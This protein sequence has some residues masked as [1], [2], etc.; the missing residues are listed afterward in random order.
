MVE[1]NEQHRFL[2]RTIIK[3]SFKDVNLFEAKNLK[4]A[5]GIFKENKEILNVVL[6]DGML[7]DG[8]GIDFIRE[9]RGFPGKIVAMPTDEGEEGA[10][11]KAKNLYESVG[12]VY[13]PKSRLTKG[14]CLKEILD[15][16]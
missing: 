4:E 2:I 7:P 15:V 5:R 6:V 16:L 14:E 1:D 3:S 10:R 9:I 11:E 13:C 8:E 12:A